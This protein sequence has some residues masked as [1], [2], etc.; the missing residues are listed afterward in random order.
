M[1]RRLLT[2]GAYVIRSGCPEAPEGKA[3]LGAQLTAAH[4][5]EYLDGLV[6]AIR[7]L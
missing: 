3:R 7:K 2:L 4:E 6:E 5:R 1:S